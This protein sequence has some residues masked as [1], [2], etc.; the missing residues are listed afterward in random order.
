VIRFAALQFRTQALLAL[1]ALVAIGIALG[2]TGPH[3]VNFYDSTVVPC[4]AH[5]DCSYADTAL[6]DLDGP[7][8][9]FLDLLVLAVPGLIG[10]FWGAPMVARELESGTVRLAWTQGVTRTRWLASKLGLGLLVSV[11]ATGLLSLM[12]T[13]WYSPIDTVSG[14]RFN[15]LTFSVRDIAPVGYAAFAFVLG[16]TAG[17]LVRRVVPAMFTTLAGFA[18][19]RYVMNT[20]IRPHLIAPI[21][22]SLAITRSTSLEI[23]ERNGAAIVNV[24]IRTINLP[25]DWVYSASLVDKAGHAPTQAVLNRA[26]VFGKDSLQLN[27]QT[28]TANLAVRFHELVIYQPSSRFWTFQWYETAIFLGLAIVLAGGGFLWIRRT[29]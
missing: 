10:L 8:Q 4:S 24:P 17:L 7:V 14:N 2:V 16:L 5:H 1:G 28:C 6:M 15:A 9:V 29:A 23:G 13:W 18:A 3:L 19:A 26:C 22:T 25:N 11:V 12:V 21:H 20:F 27:A